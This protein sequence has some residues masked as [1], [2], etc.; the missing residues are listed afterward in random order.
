[1]LFICIFFQPSPGLVSRPDRI[2]VSSS[3]QVKD[4]ILYGQGEPFSSRFYTAIVMNRV[5]SVLKSAFD[6][7]VGKIGYSCL[8]DCG[9]HGSCRCGIC[10]RGGNKLNCHIPDCSECSSESFILFFTIIIPIVSTALLMTFYIV[11]A[12][13]ISAK[14]NQ[15]DLF[16]ILGYRCCLFNIGLF[17]SRT[18]PRRF[19][20]YLGR[21]S[22]LCRLPPIPMIVLTLT[23][24]AFLSLVLYRNFYRNL[25]FVY[26][27]LPEELF[28]SDHLMIAAEIRIHM[29]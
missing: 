11:R 13:V 5:K 12:L 26:S 3:I 24:L 1:M 10:V 8:H 21:V 28:P 16:N 19:K 25:E 17:R 2:L 6:S 27:I 18:I 22:V 14:F 7:F 23:V 20:S 29:S 4:S 9:P 15:E